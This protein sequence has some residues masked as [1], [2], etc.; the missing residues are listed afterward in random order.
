[1]PARTTSS[2]NHRCVSEGA[3][4]NHHFEVEIKKFPLRRRA[5]LAICSPQTLF[6][7]S[8]KVSTFLLRSGWKLA[9]KGKLGRGSNHLTPRQKATATHLQHFLDAVDG[10]GEQGVDFL[11]VVDIIRVSD[12]HVEDVGGKAGDGRRHGLRLEI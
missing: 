6:F 2:Q 9:T 11:V 5:I 10:G 8:I 7:K 1:M 4:L 12:A 3:K